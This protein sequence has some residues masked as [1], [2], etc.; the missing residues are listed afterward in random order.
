M[1]FLLSVLIV[2]IPFIELG[3]AINGMEEERCES[4]PHEIYEEEVLD[5]EKK[6]LEYN[7]FIIRIYFV[8]A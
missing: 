2:R 3:Q 7:G 1:E 8:L 5:T 4:F 6:P